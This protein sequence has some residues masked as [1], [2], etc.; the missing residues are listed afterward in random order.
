M[1]DAGHYGY[2]NQS[3]VVPEYWESRRMWVLCEYLAEELRKFG[4]EVLKTRNDIDKFVDVY[5]RGKMSK[6]CDLFISL[7]SNAVGDKGKEATDRVDVYAAFDN[8]NESHTLAKALSKAISDVMKV[9]DGG[10]KT[11]KGDKGEYYGVMSGARKVGCPLYYIVEHSF[12]TNRYAASWLLEDENLKR[13]AVVEAAV[14]A[15][16]YGIAPI[17]PQG[18]VNMNGYLDA[19]DIILIKRAYFGMASLSEEQKKLA[20]FDENGELDASDY[21]LAKRKF[22][23]M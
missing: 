3:P 13:L 6:G 19:D 21:I 17:Y 14:I 8:Q 2:R 7:H 16:Y 5:D 15:A 1:L 23:G 12:H 9:S 11:R 20:D 22:F 4:F 18:D 10:V